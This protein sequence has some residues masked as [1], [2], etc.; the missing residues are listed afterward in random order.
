MSSTPTPSGQA[1]PRSVERVS[2]LPWPAGD[3]RLMPFLPLV[4]VAW[5]DG[6]L[7]ARELDRVREELGTVEDL[8]PKRRDVLE[9]WLQAESPPSPVALAELREVIRGLAP[10]ISPD[11]R[12]S[13]TS[14]GV[15][16]ARVKEGGSGEWGTARG[17]KALEGIEELLGILGAEAA[18]ELTAPDEGAAGPAPEARAP[19]L[20]EARLR[21]LLQEPHPEL[22]QRV[23]G[24]LRDPEV[25]VPDGLPTPEARERVLHAVRRL[26]REGLGGIAYP[27]EVGGGGDVLGSLVVFETLGF[28]NLSVLI[29]YG[30][31]FGLF[32]GSVAQLGTEAHHRKYLSRIASLEIPGIYAMTERNHGSN[33]WDLETLARYLPDADEFEISTPHP[34]AR[35]DWLG[36][37]ALHGRMATV[38][39]QL[40]V[41][42]ERHG[43]HAF[44][45]PVRDE[46]GHPLPGIGIEDCGEKVGLHGVDN[47]RLELRAVRIPRENLLDRFG[48]VTADGSYR[49]PIASP[50]RRFFTMLGTLVAGRI[51]IALG[52][53][54]AA[55]TGL[56]IAIRYGD[57]RRQFGPS[58]EPEVPILDYLAQQRALFPAL[59]TTYGLHFAVRDLAQSY[60]DGGTDEERASV[61]LLAAAL[62]ALASRNALETLQT[63]R[64]AMGGRGYL[65]ANRIGYLRED[66]DIF[67]TFEGANVVLLQLVA[68]GLLTEYRNELGDLR[69]LGI[70]KHL[71]ELAG[72]EAQRRD[73]VR[74]RRTGEDFLR[75]PETQMDAF[76]FRESRLRH[77]V[78]WRL[79]SRID[80]GTDS[81]RAMNECQDH[82]L[83]LAGAHGERIVLERF[84][85]AVDRAKASEEAPIAD[86]LSL[87]ADLYA[88]SRLERDRAWFQESGYMEGGQGKAIRGLVNALCADLRPFAVQLVDAFGIPDEI[89]AAPDAI[90]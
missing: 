46:E 1:G 71:G 42:G 90:T 17:M 49:S 36:N 63:C 88:L 26:A 53:L 75:D 84:R 86:I 31:Q 55:K 48:K 50:G 89:L 78:A 64:E 85:A 47:G 83:A 54:S 19:A 70:V 11:E 10:M 61:E 74:S 68:K 15:G 22:R 4:Y 51:S 77:T 23:M 32:G 9:S 66:I 67:T 16:M 60:A 21:S 69:L 5:S 44:L 79:K 37:A 38:F 57:R 58:G 6:I 14:L 41:G 39:A 76:T 3:A 59:A 7:S 80:E 62:K 30:V 73:P 27:V 82:L 24:L 72:E 52:S 13:L 40:E 12:R 87:L 29:K 33:V 45:V 35:K 18:R 65:A 2:P 20:P 28:G 56:A 8:D 81:F 43:V 34:D 25:R